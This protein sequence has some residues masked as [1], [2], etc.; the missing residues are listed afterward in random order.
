M[1]RR[2][3]ISLL[4][5][6]LAAAPAAAQQDMAD[7]Q[8]TAEEIA[9][10]VAVL[11]GQGGNIGVSHGEG[12]TVLIDDQFAPLSAKIEAAVAG[13]GANPVHYVI[14][15]HWHG[16]HTGGNE[17]FGK[18]GAHIFAHKNVRKRLSVDQQ[19]GERV[20]AAAPAAALPVVTYDRGV[21]LHLNGDTIE[22]MFLGGGHT[23]GDSVVFWREKNV[24]HMGD[25]Y[26]KIAGWPYIDT[27]SG[28][29]VE[30]LL[31]S[32]DSAL[33]LMDDETKVIPGH[34][35]MSNKA[36]LMA[37]RNAIGEAVT[38]IRA[39]KQSGKTVE[40]AQAA[41]PLESFQRGEG[42]IGADAFIAAIWDSL[43]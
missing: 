36:E 7:V 22:V 30:R 38:R 42:F 21:R 17:H 26:F 19:R 25:L 40:E 41:K 28:G 43:D 2:L 24:V 1:N 4:G 6:C 13:L 23:D 15:T 8:I 27:N 18:A 29:N 37:Y 16:D 14:N 5:T 33:S 3:F 34:G 31:F 9:P 32:V 10:G 12:G 35:P 39:L 11:F 20:I